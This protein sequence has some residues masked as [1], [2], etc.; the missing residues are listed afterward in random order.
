MAEM[1]RHKLADLERQ[2]LQSSEQLSFME[3]ALNA[4]LEV[5]ARQLAEESESTRQPDDRAMFSYITPEARAATRDLDI[6]LLS[7]TAETMYGPLLDNLGIVDPRRSAIINEIGQA[8]HKMQEVSFMMRNGEISPQDATEMLRESNPGQMLRARLAE[9]I[10]AEGISDYLNGREEVNV[11]RDVM[12]DLSFRFRSTLSVA[13]THAFAALY[14]DEVIASTRSEDAGASME[15]RQLVAM[16]RLQTT[17]SQMYPGEQALQLNAFLASR[18]ER[19]MRSS[20][21][22]TGGE[23]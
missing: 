20:S 14:Y 4:P 12:E 15:D 8:F 3:T 22:V 21:R 6:E 23:P 16:D 13:D 10:S 5:L 7:M 19:L 18:K 2:S 17:V 1:L 9:E 11:N